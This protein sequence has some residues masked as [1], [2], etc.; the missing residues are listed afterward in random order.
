MTFHIITYGC[1]M[2]ERDSEAIAALLLQQ[3]WEWV[4]HSARAD[5]LLVNTCSVRARAEEKALGRLRLAA[6][7]KNPGGPRKVVA[8]GC[9]AELL[10]TSLLQAIPGLDAVVGPARLAELPQILRGILADEGPTVHTGPANQPVSFLT[11]HLPS[12]PTAF[13]TILAGCNGACTYCVVPRTRGRAWSRPIVEILDEVRQAVDLG[14]R[15][16]TFLG[17]NVTAYGQG[18]PVGEPLEPSVLGLTEPLPRLLEATARIPG[19]LRIRFEAS[20]PLGCTPE[21]ARAIRAIDAVCEHVHLPCQSGSDRILRLMARGYTTDDYRRAVERLRAAVPRLAL[22]TDVIVGFPSETQ[23]DFEQ[24]ARFL[25]EID[26]DNAFIFKY[27]PRPGTPA[28][29]RPDDVTPEEKRRRH[30]RLLEEQNRRS[31]RKNQAWVQRTVEVLVEGPSARRPARWT[32]RTRENRIVL[33]DPLPNTHPGCLARVKIE[34]AR[35]QTLHGRI[36]E[37]GC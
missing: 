11:G 34:H 15:E 17:Q 8:V 12:S 14:A 5:V 37:N 4:P 19:V 35:P 6:A 1:Q 30:A 9:T 36:L 13:V 32:G 26:F 24:T 18:T 27:S 29:C 20:H 22:T 28:A 16:I 31:L 2:N 10:G 3:G 23:E 21:L 7:A 33:F 25:S